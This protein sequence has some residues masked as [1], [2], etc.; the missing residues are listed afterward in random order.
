MN[1][2][3]ALAVFEPS[4]TVSVLLFLHNSKAAYDCSETHEGGAVWL[5]QPF[6]KDRTKAAIGDLGWATE[7]IDYQEQRRLTKYLQ[8][9]N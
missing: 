3:I 8:L 9:F 6:M 1:M 7:D 2:L 5:F 4:D